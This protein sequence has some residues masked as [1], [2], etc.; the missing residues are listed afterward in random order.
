[1]EISV[2]NWK[3]LFDFLYKKQYFLDLLDFLDQEYNSKVIYPEKKNL[4]NLI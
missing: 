3:N 2:K 4:F 1:M